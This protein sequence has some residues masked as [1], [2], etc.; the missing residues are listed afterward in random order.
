MLLLCCAGD[1]L[2]LLQ[3]LGLTESGDQT[4]C[5]TELVLQRHR[6]SAL[7]ESLDQTF[8]QMFVRMFVLMVAWMVDRMV[9]LTDLSLSGQTSLS[10]H[11]F[12]VVQTSLPV[13][14][15][16]VAKS[17]P[18]NQRGL[19][20]LIGRHVQ[21][22][23]IAQRGLIAQTG[24]IVQ[25]DQIVQRGQIAW[26]EQTVQTGQI[27]W[28]GRITWRGLRESGSRSG[29]G[30][31]LCLPILERVDKGSCQLHPPSPASPCQKQFF[32]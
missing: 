24:L 14:H 13:C 31:G 15:T 21:R 12:L 28:R 8:V 18:T 7:D 32:V 20:G 3:L 5:L 26:R 2:F 19:N 30:N 27:A 25:T 23:Q 16:L 22:G 6:V 29:T 4:R 11:P 9:I 17:D 10:V 1:T